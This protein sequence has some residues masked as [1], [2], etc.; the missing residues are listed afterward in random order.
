ME[1]GAPEVSPTCPMVYS[2]PSLLA[3]VNHPKALVNI[4]G[5]RYPS[6]CEQNAYVDNREMR[7]SRRC[8]RW[9]ETYRWSVHGTSSYGSAIEHDPNTLK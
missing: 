6:L 7:W 3:Y 4:V 9:T 8:E 1:M 2:Y 5:Y